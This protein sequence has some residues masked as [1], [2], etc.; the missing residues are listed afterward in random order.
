MVD[1]FVVEV[2]VPPLYISLHVKECEGKISTVAVHTEE[3][4][5]LR[6]S[7]ERVPEAKSFFIFNVLDGP[8]VIVP[9]F[10]E[11]LMRI[12]VPDYKIMPAVETLQASVADVLVTFEE[13]ARK[14]ES[15]NEDV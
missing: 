9:K 4:E 15:E 13:E 5:C 10:V 2:Q 14:M 12:D 1:I 6:L 3:S 7:Q 8:A 11:Y